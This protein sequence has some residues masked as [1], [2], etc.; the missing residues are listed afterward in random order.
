MAS[1][2]AIVV[3]ARTPVTLSENKIEMPSAKEDL[4]AVGRPVN[5]L[6]DEAGEVVPQSDSSMSSS[7]KKEDKGKGSKN[8][9]VQK[10]GDYYSVLVVPSF[11]SI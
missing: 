8:M 1:F 5:A 7:S 10:K 11:F 4:S 9:P 6:P 3:P 2:V